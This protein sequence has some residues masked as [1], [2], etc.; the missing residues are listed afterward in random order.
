MGETVDKFRGKI[1]AIVHRNDDVEENIGRCT[2]E[3]ELYRGRN[4]RAD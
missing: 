3:D 2:C 4:R 1:I